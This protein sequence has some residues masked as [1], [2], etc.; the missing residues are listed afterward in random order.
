MIVG[1]ILI[2]VA[3]AVITALTTRGGGGDEKPPPPKEARLRALPPSVHNPFNEME[4]VK[5][6]TF[7]QADAAKPRIDVR[8]HNVGDRRSVVTS[9][10]ITITRSARVTACGI[11]APLFASAA[12]EVILPSRPRDG[13][14]LE[15][16]IDQQ[17]GVD[18]ADRFSFRFGTREAFEADLGTTVFYE[19]KLEVLHDGAAAPLDVG[20]ATIAVPGAPQSFSSSDAAAPYGHFSVDEECLAAPPADFR[21]AVGSFRGTHSPELDEF[22]A[23]LRSGT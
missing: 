12:Y 1:P 19:L 4:Q 6:G 7:R 11:G 23:Y 3:G 22:V 2:L 18:K 17:L 15:V 13:Q 16:P 14:V 8:L 5:A 20:R 9:A 21:A 10:R